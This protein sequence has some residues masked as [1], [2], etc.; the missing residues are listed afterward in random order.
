MF[1]IIRS[2][3]GYRTSPVV[4]FAGRVTGRFAEGFSIFRYSRL[5]LVA[6]EGTSFENSPT[7]NTS[8]GALTNV[9]SYATN[10][11]SFGFSFWFKLM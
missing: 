11:T 2:H 1:F 9:Y 7:R 10:S 8:P 6:S 3:A 5:L 4:L